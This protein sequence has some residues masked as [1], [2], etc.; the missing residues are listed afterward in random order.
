M[1]KKLLNE[2]LISV[3]NNYNINEGYEDHPEAKAK[4]LTPQAL[5]DDMNK[6]LGRINTVAKDRVSRGVKDVIYH[7]KQIQSVIN[8]EG[9][10]D[11]DKFKTL[12][13]TPPKLIFDK[14]PKME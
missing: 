7:K 11:V 3:Y 6:E 1:I 2:S 10:L 14:N 12:K 9:G 4:C 8:Q 5:A 13:T